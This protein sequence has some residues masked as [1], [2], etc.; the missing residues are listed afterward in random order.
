MSIV[1]LTP[2][3]SSSLLSFPTLYHRPCRHLL[4]SQSIENVCVATLNPSTLN[5]SSLTYTHS[6]GTYQLANINLHTS[7]R[8]T[9]TFGHHTLAS[10]ARTSNRDP[11]RSSRSPHDKASSALELFVLVINHR[12]TLNSTTSLRPRNNFFRVVKLQLGSLI[13]DHRLFVSQQ[14]SPPI[15]LHNR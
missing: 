8:P 13:L 10:L 6:T 4:R 7:T 5:I 12:S 3:S 15:S 9:L 2:S 14:L 1:V 11:S